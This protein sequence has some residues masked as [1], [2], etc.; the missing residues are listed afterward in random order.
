[1]K[2]HPTLNLTA[3]TAA[4][5][6]AALAPKAL[7][8]DGTWTNQASGNWSDANNWLN[9]AIAGGSGSTAYFN[10]IDVPT[11]SG[12]ITVTVDYS[13]AVNFFGVT[14]ANLYFGDTVTN[15]GAAGWTLAEG[16]LGITLDSK[17]SSNSIVDVNL[18]T[19]ANNNLVAGWAMLTN[20]VG[21]HGTNTL[22]K[23][24]PSPMLITAANDYTGGTIIS[25][26]MIRVGANINNTAF[27]SGP[28]F[29]YGG[30]L[31]LWQAV[32]PG[33]STHVTVGEAGLPNAIV[34]PDGQ[35]GTLYLTPYALPC[36]SGP[37]SGGGTLN[38]FVDYVRDEL[39]NDWSGF[40]GNLVV[41]TTVRGSSD[42][43][44][45]SGF[46]PAGLAGTT[47]I[48]T[49]NPFV[50]SVVSMYNAGL[51]A[52]NFNIGAMVDTVP[53]AVSIASH[54]TT[55]GTKNSAPMILTV[56]G[57]N[58]DA[59]F[60]GNFSG[61]SGGGSI[62]IIKVGTGTWILDGPTV[63]YA[64]MTVVSNGVLQVGMGTSGK[65]GLSPVVTNYATLA[66]GRSDTMT[67]TNVIDGPGIVEQVGSGTL[68]LAPSAA[69]NTY[70][71]KTVVKAGSL[72]VGNLSALGASPASFTADQL[73]LDGGS[74]VAT[75]DF[76]YNDPNRGISFGASGGGL[77]ADAGST[78]TV[79]T[80]IGGAG[81]LTIND[82]GMVS[83]QGANT[84]TGKTILG[85]GTLVL[86]QLA[87]LGTAP[88]TA[89]PDQLTLN[90]G[91]LESTATFAIDDANRGVTVG[92]AGGTI[93]PDAA[94]TLT[95]SEP[96]TGSGTLTKAGAGTLMINGAD[97]SAGDTMIGQG[98]LAVGAGG[99]ISAS[100]M[101]SVAAGATLDVSASS[102]SLG[103]GQTLTG[104]G[105]IVGGFNAGAGSTISAGDGVGTLTFN[106]DLTLAG[107]TN[108]VEIASSSND[109][110]NVTG[111][112]TLTGVSTIQ[113]TLLEALPNGNYPLIQYG[114]TLTGTAANLVLQGYPLSRR[115]AALVVDSANHSIDLSISGSVGNLVWTG[116]S[117]G[118]AWDVDSTLNWLNGGSPDVF[119][120][121]D[122]PTF[123]D[124]GSS[125]PVVNIAAT[126]QPGVVTVDSTSDYTFSGPGKISGAASLAKSGS[127][128][129]TVLT[130][131]DF[132][133]GATISAGT[134]Q[135]GNGTSGGALG[136]G[137]IVDN[138][139]LNFNLPSA[140]NV[141]NPISGSGSV[142][143]QGGT[144]VLTADNSYGA[145]S[146]SSG[147]TLQAGNGGASGSVGTGAVANDGALIYNR[148][149]TVTNAG[150]ISGSGDLTVQGG[151]TV[152]LAADNSYSGATLV[153]SGT[154]QVGA[155]GAAGTLGTAASVTV[156]SGGTLAFARSDTTTNSVVVTGAGALRQEAGTL[157]LVSS[158]SY[159]ATL[160]DSGSTLQIGDG[161]TNLAYVVL[162]TN[163]D[164]V[165]L[166]TNVVTNFFG[167][168]TLGT[169]GISDDGTLVLAQP[170][171]SIL[172]NDITGAGSVVSLGAGT[173]T[174]QKTTANTYSGGTTISNSAVI[175]AP[176]AGLGQAALN[177][178]VTIL[179]QSGLGTG[180]LTFLGTNSTLQMAWADQQD[181]QASVSPNFAYTI[182]VPAGQSGTVWAQ[183]RYVDN[184]V[185]T[186]GGTYNI[187]VNYVRDNF[188]GDWSGF[189]GQ[190][191][192]ITNA[193]RTTG[194][195]TAYDFREY[196]ANG[197][198][199]AK[200][201]IGPGADIQWQGSGS[202]FVPL[203][204][205]TGDPTSFV[206]SGNWTVGGLNTDATY[207][208][209][210]SGGS[211]VKT[212]TGKWTLTAQNTTGGT[213]TVSNGVL[214]F[215]VSPV[216]GVTVGTI[217][218]AS[219][220]IVAAPGVIDASGYAD[221]NLQ[222]SSTL[223]GDGTVKGG[224]IDNGIVAP[225]F[226]TNL[227]GNLTIS[228]NLVVYGT[229]QFKI[230]QNPLPVSDMITC[231]NVT[232]NDGATI[233]VT[234]I[235]TND[236][237]TGA[238]FK[239]FSTPATFTNI[240]VTLPAQNQDGSIT[241]V[242]T[243]KLAIDGTVALLSGAAPT[244]NTNP[245]PIQ[246]SIAANTLSLSWP[247]NSGWTLQVQTN[248]LGSG[249]NPA[250]WVDLVPGNT[251]VTSTNITINPGN[252]SVF[253]R[254]KL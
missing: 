126:V 225:G 69:A 235:S 132:I 31:E 195:S 242:W 8:A 176:P 78:L 177:S 220:I 70:T 113:V 50:S 106:G 234:E 137:A 149:G 188:Q 198:P 154:L 67:V 217:A 165:N 19:G 42:F 105:T 180:P 3:L 219:S 187:G 196:N 23:S 232:F 181:P 218:S 223:G 21:L 129:L 245:P 128:T 116:G 236:L 224:V 171:A 119:F 134:V 45:G 248:T 34:V 86:A 247:T 12:G 114:G 85:S 226:S 189:T 44:I 77:G 169:G 200:V 160:L 191:N 138:A 5:V 125:N 49:N 139:A 59:E 87:S 213:M 136:T 73:T 250:N 170:Y 186:G 93:S 79:T 101:I 7:A 253:Y 33:S 230:D 168:V 140:M 118:N 228:S 244:L 212:G 63:A 37:V 122:N 159:G 108:L 238:T 90:G 81:D 54:N 205:L 95:I 99:S 240:N 210:I 102:F 15:D 231:T 157:V 39:R 43:R 173:L 155:G 233:S 27:G 229:V 130:T 222:I 14:N 66:F 47:L 201:Y 80:P 96:I 20:S 163:I 246:V 25:N 215:G 16:G 227:V 254:L 51:P 207:D 84:Y 152:V 60:A 120:N 151:G 167:S 144:A 174:I 182:N 175:L 124:V 46:N 209:T 164:T 103:A 199:N 26:G 82:A 58:T 249:L 206:T 156:N 211:I 40:T 166:I 184:S 56:G 22:V 148:T 1:M 68:I 162:T 143:V 74:F 38:L 146:I 48:F 153:D 72:A 214:A 65:L 112:L 251:G 4:M 185:L 135:V 29:F 71:G 13:D 158:N 91:T 252:P 190:L 98:T 121:G 239:L 192:I 131:N 92:S 28:I 221:N 6:L 100:P 61:D 203:G 30:S 97:T 145:S 2:P 208:G 193:V 41:A 111:N 35:T 202:P 109:M 75:S 88:A 216:D 110:L 147:A 141:D 83:L 107:A 76:V 237:Q 117:N 104:N 194:T 172:T 142:A 178:A 32:I 24:G 9:G 115:T 52:T 10:T 241:Y 133:G 89:T 127:D 55:P 150:A 53:G 243:N 57:L 64:G 179:N 62:G 94:T 17:T 11:N 197:V 204:E 183:G 161:D 36:L 18:V 123:S